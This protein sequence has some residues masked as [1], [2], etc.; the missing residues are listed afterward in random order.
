MPSG[1]VRCAQ[2]RYRNANFEY[3][4]KNIIKNFDDKSDLMIYPDFEANTSMN[5]DSNY[6]KQKEKL[7]K[8][9]YTF[10]K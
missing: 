9:K 2:I 7:S 8:K 6:Q 1:A 10:M 4:Y 5:F 3:N